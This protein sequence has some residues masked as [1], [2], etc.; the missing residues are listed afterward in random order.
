MKRKV[1]TV[2]L[3]SAIMLAVIACGKD[4]TVETMNTDTVVE[5]NV[6][7]KTVVEEN[8]TEEFKEELE[9]DVYEPYDPLSQDNILQ[10]D[11]G[12]YDFTDDFLGTVMSYDYFRESTEQEVKDY[13]NEIVEFI[14]DKSPEEISELLGALGYSTGSTL[15]ADNDALNF[16]IIKMDAI[17]YAT[18]NVNV[19]CGISAEYDKL[20]GLT[21][22]E[23]VHV[24]GQSETTGWYE[25]E[26]NGAK[27]Y[28]SNN[29]LSASKVEV[30]PPVQSNP[31]Q[32]SGGTG[33][34]ITDPN[35]KIELP[36]S[37]IDAG[38]TTGNF[39]GG[40]HNDGGYGF[41]VH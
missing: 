14:K 38:I 6:S 33:G 25:I 28:V 20:G 23:E 16:G 34:L 9:E 17:M 3:G 13:L 5:E 24:T 41:D 30:A 8:V 18:G 39:G 15:K 26:F 11:D 4:E 7:D 35:Y 32:P 19:R 10:L 31:S 2:I 1:V 36:Q 37:A 21:T 40:E 12:T 22:N 27:G 29:Y